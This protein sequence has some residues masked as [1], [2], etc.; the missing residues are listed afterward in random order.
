MQC[1]GLP[2]GAGATAAPVASARGSAAGRTP[3]SRVTV[4]DLPHREPAVRAR[5]RR[6][7]VSAG[8][9]GQNPCGR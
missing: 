6:R 4:C 8:P 9:T 1:P 2:G 3:G 5:L 7:G